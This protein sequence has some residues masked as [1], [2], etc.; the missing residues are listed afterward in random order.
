MEQTS[1]TPLEMN[2]CIGARIKQSLAYIPGFP[3]HKYLFPDITPMLEQ[4]PGL[5]REVIAETLRRT[6]GWRYD[7][8]LCIESFGYIFGVPIAHQRGSRIVLMRRPGKLPRPTLEYGYAMCYD[9]KRRMEIHAGALI[10]ESR[11][12]VVDD[13]L[14]SGGTIGAALELI[15]QA[16]ATAAG[17]ACIVENLSWKGRIALAKYAVPIVT[18]SVID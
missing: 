4:D 3:D 7:T 10:P 15:S 6:E 13:F 5:F 11:V 8:V 14:I 18:L 17:V 9:A 16:K 12:L 2:A 1:V